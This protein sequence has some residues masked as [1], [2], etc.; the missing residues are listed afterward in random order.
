M[1]VQ[2]FYK[3]IFILICIVMVCTISSTVFAAM[4]PVEVEKRNEQ[5]PYQITGEVTSDKL[6]K[7]VT[8]NTKH[9]IQVRKVTIEIS[10]VIKAPT[11]LE[12][13]N[14]VELY[15]HYI[16]S[17]DASEYVGGARIDIAIGD[18]VTVWLSKGDY[19]WEPAMGGNSIKHLTYSENRVDY[20]PEPFLHKVAGMDRTLGNTSPNVFVLCGLLAILGWAFL[21]GLRKA[22]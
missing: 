15:Y 20:V 22:T 2:Q 17:W 16:P 12:K 10:E 9:P 3:R 8:E 21:R 1:K 11:G 4:D 14:T 7:D 13:N 19:G 18:V 6:Y 5:A